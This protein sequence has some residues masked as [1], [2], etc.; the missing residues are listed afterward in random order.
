MQYRP[1][2]SD[3]PR[4]YGTYRAPF[5]GPYWTDP[6]APYVAEEVWEDEQGHKRY[7]HVLR[8]PQRPEPVT[9]RKRKLSDM[10]SIKLTEESGG[11]FKRLETGV[12]NA[13]CDL[14]ADLGMRE[15][16][17]GDKHKVYIRFAIPDQTVEKEDGT[18]F[19]MSIG[20]QYTAS[21]N[22]KANLR[23]MLENWRGKPFTDEELKGFE[24]TKLLN[25]PATVV[26]GS[27]VDREGKE[28]P[29]IESVIRC[30]ANVEPLDHEAVAFGLDSTERELADAPEWI[31]E[32]IRE[33][34]AKQ[35]IAE[36]N[37][38][39]QDAA[40]HQSDEDEGY[41]ND[42]VPF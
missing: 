38:A 9:A 12:Y 25:A 7:R 24:L 2:D 15:T 40:A 4:A 30:K 23:K 17:F 3:D 5:V 6:W 1:L 34:R 36:A 37:K 20:S 33:A 41:Y 21:L 29:K 28:R 8:T 13:R 39:E 27:Y 19:Q 16:N 42:D 35:N 22:K 11:D 32:A 26:V 10:A 18:T 14:L 31:S